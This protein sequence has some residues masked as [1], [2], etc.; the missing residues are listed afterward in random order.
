MALVNYIRENQLAGMPVKK[1]VDEAVKR[2]IKEGFH[3]RQPPSSI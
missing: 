3:Y 2:C 1:A